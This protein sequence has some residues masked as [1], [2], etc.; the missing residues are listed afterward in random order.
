[1]A[2]NKTRMPLLRAL[3]VQ[4]IAALIV[5]G[6]LGSALGI[7]PPMTTLLAAQGI[8]AATLGHFFG[9]ARWWLPIHVLLPAAVAITLA[10]KVPGWVFLIAFLGLLG[11]F[12]NSVRGG[13]PLYLSNRKTRDALTGLLPVAGDFHFADLGCGFAGP[14]LALAKA[15]PDGRF[16]GFETA[17]LIVAAAKIRLGFQAA[18]NANIHFTN[19]WSVDWGDYDVVYC[20]LSPVPMPALYDKARRDMKPGSLLISNSFA[21]PGHP[22]DDIIDVDDRRQTRLHL[23]RM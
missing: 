2:D 16:T 21:V 6:G 13:V 15:R 7:H 20:F 4:A 3:A 23:W 12:W 11:I 9:L 5:F 17:P 14:V 1:M 18:G 22:A 8:I 19:I 10:W